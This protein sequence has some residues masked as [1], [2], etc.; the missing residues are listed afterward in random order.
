MGFY[1]ATASI[2]ESHEFESAIVIVLLSEREFVI[3][4]RSSFRCVAHYIEINL[5]TSIFLA[6]GAL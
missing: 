6:E 4:K 3:A 1:H 5:P 2:V